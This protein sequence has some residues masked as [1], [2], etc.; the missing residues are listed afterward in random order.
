MLLSP[1]DPAPGADDVPAGRWATAT[2]DLHA[3]EEAASA[4]F[5]E[6]LLDPAAPAPEGL[7]G[8]NGKRAVK[9]YAV[10]R[11]NVVVG[12][13]DALAAAFP[14]VQRIVGEEFFRAAARVHALA[15]PPSSPLMM[16]YGRDFPAFLEGFE[17]A[18]ALPYLAD[19]ARVER[20]WLDAIHAADAAPLDPAALGAVPPE[21]LGEVR[22]ER[23]PAAHVIRSPYAVVSATAA[24]RS[25]APVD[26]IAMDSAEDGL[27][28]RPHLEVA[29]ITL[30]PGGGAFL[31]ALFDGR[32]LGEAAALATEDDP[33]FD[34]AANIGGALG[35]GAFSGLA[36]PDAALDLSFDPSFDPSP[37]SVPQADAPEEESLP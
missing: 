19:V 32:P 9:R 35:A 20:L 26:P 12:L 29:L 22:L 4:T 30:P 34:L 11:N 21:R 3:A 37:E 25:D 8:P 24:N 5:A 6:A 1:D 10:Y 13:V 36:L 17:P 14:A 7:T 31:L 15:S 28:V 23:H 18:A 2:P 27:I 33:A 16:E